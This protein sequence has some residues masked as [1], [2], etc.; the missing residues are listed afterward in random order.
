[1]ERGVEVEGSV[2]QLNL[3]LF[4][5]FVAWLG[6]QTYQRGNAPERKL[7]MRTRRGYVMAATG[8]FRFLVVDGK[9]PDVT[10]SDFLAAH[11]RANRATRCNDVPMEKKLPPEG[12]VEAIVDA[13]R[14]EPDTSRMRPRPARRVRLTWLRNRA[15][16]L[17]LY[18]TGMRVG[19]VH[20]LLRDDLVYEDQGAWINGKGDKTRFVRFSDEAWDAIMEYLDM[21]RDEA[22]G[23][24]VPE[25]PVFCRHN[26]GT[27]DYRRLPLSTVSIEKLITTLARDTGV[28]AR[29][30]MTPHS[31]RHYFATR[32][33]RH[34]GDL[35]LTQDVMGH[36][37][38]ITT[39]LYAKTSKEQHIA[40]HKSLFNE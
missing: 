29:F 22:L 1:M 15:I 27:G 10:Y 40:A 18:C 3:S 16:I 23:G 17:V 20:R 13:I 30:H 25:Y 35:A 12:A 19:E 31:F 5:S 9:L 36:S 39:R 32:F 21:R 14:Q 8:F 24:F 7:S 2:E 26:T 33:L 6:K 37:S 11:D 4:R 34:T 38:P 28:L